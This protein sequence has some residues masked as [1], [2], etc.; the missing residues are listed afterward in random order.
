[1]NEV[2]RLSSVCAQA[3]ECFPMPS[4][5]CSTRGGDVEHETCIQ[6]CEDSENE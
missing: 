1:M 5:I 4:Y 6:G 3:I 2:V